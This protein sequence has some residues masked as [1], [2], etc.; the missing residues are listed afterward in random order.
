MMDKL[1]VYNRLVLLFIYVLAE[2][3]YELKKKF[4]SKFLYN[5]LQLSNRTCRKRWYLANESKH[6]KLLFIRVSVNHD[7]KAQISEPQE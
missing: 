1:Y 4:F 3:Q 5:F 2:Y 7:R 6:P